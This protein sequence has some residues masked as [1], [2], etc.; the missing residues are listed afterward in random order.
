MSSWGRVGG[1][2][3][4]ASIRSPLPGSNLSLLNTVVP[5]SIS[6]LGTRFFCDATTFFSR[7]GHTK[8]CTGRAT[9]M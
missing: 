1:L 8:L 3:V 9:Q 2:E 5:T 6:E 4:N 7:L